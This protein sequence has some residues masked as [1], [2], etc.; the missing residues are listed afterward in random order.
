MVTATAIGIRVDLEVDIWEMFMFSGLDLSDPYFFFCSSSSGRRG[1][2]SQ[3][4]ALLAGIV[5]KTNGGWT[6]TSRSESDQIRSHI[7]Q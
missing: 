3:F 4:F 1:S 7:V 2:S 5:S 6:W